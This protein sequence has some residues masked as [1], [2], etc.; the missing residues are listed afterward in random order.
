MSIVSTLI[1]ISVVGYV[2]VNSP[3]WDLVQESFLNPKYA[4]AAWPKIWA[5]FGRNVALFLMA[6]VLVLMLGL[7]IAIMRSLKGPVFTPVRGFAIIYVDVFRGLPGILVVYVL[8]LGLPALGLPSNPFFWGL[9]ALVLIYSA[10]V[11]EVYRAGI[12]SVH[13]SQDAAARSLGLSQAQSMR[14]VVV[15]Q[16]I[17]RIIPPLLNDF[18]GLTKDTALVS[19]IGVVEAFRRG[20]IEYAGSFNFTPIVVTGVLFLVLTIPMSRFVDWLVERDRR[21]QMATA[22]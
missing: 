6:E 11:S 18:I 21:R 13:P 1:V 15:P 4:A 17:R 3:G 10:Y 7:L 8:G 16:A 9:L 19:L 20:Q 22:R 14:W 2:V 12:E 5:A